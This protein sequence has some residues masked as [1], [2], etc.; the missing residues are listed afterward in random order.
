VRARVGG[1][2]RGARGQ[3]GEVCSSSKEWDVTMCIIIECV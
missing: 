2:E 3:I 1:D